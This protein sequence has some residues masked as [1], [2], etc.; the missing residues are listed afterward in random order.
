L[1]APISL[2]EHPSL[3][4]STRRAA[5]MDTGRPYLL[6]DGN[7][8]DQDSQHGI[9]TAFSVRGGVPRWVAAQSGGNITVLLE[10]PATP[11]TSGSEVGNGEPW[12]RV[13]WRVCSRLRR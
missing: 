11:L 6:S 8:R 4:A 13:Q 7:T 10:T 5:G 12:H 3:F 1:R 2:D 9:E